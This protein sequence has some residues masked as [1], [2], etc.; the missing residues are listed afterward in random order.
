MD[1]LFGILNGFL[2]FLG[3]ETPQEMRGEREWRGNKK[4]R[5]SLSFFIS[6]F[7]SLW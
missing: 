6:L 4:R 1:S 2:F 7:L 5:G 3:G